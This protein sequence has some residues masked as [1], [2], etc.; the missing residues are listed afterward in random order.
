MVF[1]PIVAKIIIPDY[2]DDYSSLH[3]AQQI[4]GGLSGNAQG[5]TQ[6]FF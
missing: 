2:D 3:K 5:L 1:L 4:S 6:S